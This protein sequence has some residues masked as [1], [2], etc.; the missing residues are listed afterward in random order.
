MRKISHDWYSYCWNIYINNWVLEWNTFP[1]LWNMSE[2]FFWN[3]LHVKSGSGMINVMMWQVSHGICH[4]SFCTFIYFRYW[5]LISSNNTQ[6]SLSLTITYWHETHSQSWSEILNFNIH[7]S[8][9][10]NQE[11][12]WEHHLTCP[13]VQRVCSFI[14]NTSK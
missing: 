1:L 12:L 6:W 11:L 13:L 3:C 9:K 8:L 14:Y 5:F 7:L 2:P 10:R 4:A